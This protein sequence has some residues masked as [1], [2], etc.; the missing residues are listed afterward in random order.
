MGFT[1]SWG[2]GVII[3]HEGVERVSQMPLRGPSS[4]ESCKFLCSLLTSTSTS[5][6]IELIKSLKTS[7]QL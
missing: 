4:T 6:F 7:H 1:K 2:A 5:T 3:Q